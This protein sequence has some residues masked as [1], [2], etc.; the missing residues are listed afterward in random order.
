MQ[1]ISLVEAITQALAYELAADPSVVVF[2]EDVGLNGGVFR[3]TDGLQARFGEHRVK[4]TPL[5][6]AMIAGMAR[7]I[8]DVL[9]FTI[10]EG[11]PAR[12]RVIN[13]VGMERAGY[14]ND[15][16]SEVRKAFRI[17]FMREHRLDD[18]VNEVKSTFPES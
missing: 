2:G 8:Q 4:D 17:L 15:E 5:A 14:S 6:E 7:A 10:A 3:A 18:A 12:M 9:P 13:K 1:A 11:L 16:I